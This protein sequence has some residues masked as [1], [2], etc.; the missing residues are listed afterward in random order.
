MRINSEQRWSV[1]KETVAG[2]QDKALELF[3]TKTVDARIELDLNRRSS[4]V[5]A[6]SPPPM[7]Q[8]EATQSPIAQEPPLEKEYDEHDD[9]DNGFEMNDN[10]VGD[11]DKYLT[12]E[13]MDHSIPYSRCYASDSDDD[14]PDE[15][16]DEDGL[17]AK[18]AERAEIFKKRIYNFDQEDGEK[19]P[20]AWARF[21]SL[22]RAQPDHDLEKHDLLDIFYSGL[23]IES[24]AYLDS[25]AGCVFRKRTPDDAEELL[26]KIGRN[27]DDWSTP[28][29]TPTPIVK[30][31]GMIKLNDEDMREAKKSLK[32][33]GIKPEDVKNLPPI[34]D[35]CETIPPSSMIEDPLYPEGHPKR[36]EQDSQLIKT[37]APSK[38]KKKKHKNVV[39]SSEP[40]N[41]PNSISISDAETESGNEHEEDND[42]NDTPDKEEIEKEPEKH[43][44]N[45]KYTKEDFITEKHGAVIDCNKGMV[46]FNVD[47]KEHTVYFPKRI[48]KDF[49]FHRSRTD[50]MV[51]YKI[52]NKTIDLPFSDF[53][54]AIRVPQWGSCEKI[55]GTPRELSNLYTRI[56]NGRSFSNDGGKI[57]S[58]QHPAIRYFAYF[59]TKGYLTKSYSRLCGAENT[60]EKRALRRAGIRRGN[61]LPEGEIDAIAIV[62]ELD[63]ISI[64]I[65]IIIIISTIYT[66]I[67]TAAP[68]HRCNNLGIAMNEVR[69]KLFT[70]SLSGKAAH[71]YKL[72]KNGDSID[73]EDI[74]PLFY[75]KF[76]PPSE[77]HKD[78]NRIYNFWP[79]DGESIAQAWGRLKSLM[80]KCPIH[81]LPGNV[82]ID[83]FYARLSFQDKTLLDTSCSG[84][85]TRNK[86]EFK[87]DLL[88]RIQE[89]TEGWENDKDR[90]SGIIYDYKC[91]E[92]F[93]DT[94][95]FRNM[96]AT[97]GLD[98]QVVA[99]LYKAF[100]SHYELPKKNFDKYHE[101]Y[102]DNVDS[103]V[104]K[105]VVIET[106]DNVIPEVYIE[107]T[108]FPAKM[109]EYSVISSAVN[110][111]EKKPKEPEEQ[112]KIE[113]AVA[114]VKDLVTENVEDGHIIFC[115]DASNIVSHPNKPKQVSVPMLS[116]RIGDHCYYGLCD[117]GA[118]VSAIPYELYTEIM[119]EIDSC[120]LEDIDV[121]IQLANRETISPIGIVRDVE[122]LCGKIKYPADFLV[123]GSAASDHCPIIFGRPFLNTCGAIIDCKKE[124]ILTKFA[125]EPY[126]F[127]F[128]K[129]TKTP[130]KADLPSNDFKMEQCASIVLVP[131][132][133]L[134][135]HLENSESEAFRKE[136][137]ELE[138]IFL[139]QPILKHDLPVEDL[140]TTPPPKEDP[141][142][143]L[144]PLPDN[145][146]YAHIDDKKIYPVIISS[147]LSEIE[148]ERLLEILKKHRGAIG[149]TLDDLKGISPSICQH[150]INM[151]DDAKP[152]VE[153]QRRLIP[154]MKEVVRN[155]VLKLL[156]A[157]IIYP[158]ADSRW[159]SPVHCVPKKGGM[160][161]VPNDND[162]LIPQRVV[163]GRMPF[164]LC[165]APATF[166]RCMSAIFHGFCESIVERCEE[167]NLVLN[168]EKCHFMVNEGIVLGHKI[169]ERGIEVDRAKVEAIEKM[170]YPRDVKGIRSVLGHAGFYRR[171]IKD[172]SKISKP[173]TN[174]LQKDVPFVFDD[175]C[176]EA[177]ET[178][179]KALTTAPVVEPPDWNLPFEIMC[180]ASDFA[181]GAVLGQRVDKKLN[182]IHYASKTLDAAQRNYATTEKELLAVVFACDKFRPYIV[183]SK[184]T[185]HTDHAA[186]R[187]LM[188]KKDAKPRLIRWVLLL[189]EF[190]LHIIDRKGADNPV[191]DNLSR[192]ENIAYDPVP[193]NDSFPNE[194][195]AVIKV[196][197]RESPCTMVS[198]NKDKGPLEE[199]IQDPELKEED[200]SEDE[201]EVEEAPRV[202]QRATI[203]SIG[204]ISNPSN[205]KRSARIATG[206]AVPRHYL[207]PRTSSPG[208]YSPFRNLIYD[209]QTERTPKVVLPSGWDIDRSNI[210]GEMKSE[211]E[212]WGNNSRSWDSPPDMIMSRVEHNSELIRNLTYEIED[213]KELVKKLVEKNPSPSPPK[214]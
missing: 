207:A 153:H 41:D 66:A 178:L 118:S 80:L 7:S 52:Y 205:T 16:L 214:E 166:Q 138:E 50:P 99:N 148:E 212:G 75:S 184:V 120:E 51:R 114:I 18:E 176:K 68:R 100:A 195:L 201:E 33:K 67:T 213:L 20:E 131:N 140:G 115:E 57:S 149:Y 55:R 130:Y 92:A 210:A 9:G 194:Q 70:I 169:S 158:I 145:L 39:E 63:I 95:K 186:I 132:N 98:S 144:K 192:L 58:I 180:D 197:S 94:D 193:V 171:F 209:R 22:I 117:I 188:T 1:Y 74:V 105:C 21:C 133:P 128:S 91:I 119:H 107:K 59:I 86:E 102:K 127:N 185:I 187:Y 14:G 89:N 164:G 112:I 203:A 40:V 101:P 2:S 122:V 196:S 54:T 71:W 168:W 27:H 29:P 134:Q 37:S 160:T 156:E 10:N 182:V 69:K 126:E 60:R 88:D 42:K 83:N 103:S 72:L 139:R 45:K 173:L 19:L 8:E 165:N 191:A 35:I 104:N 129:F 116:V 36:V 152:V 38:K 26:A 154:K 24:R 172:F 211:A 30:K 183:D 110:K 142:F 167:T 49:E 179:K 109:K 53:C 25:C 85:F 204:V 125:G 56:C 48:D 208:N 79:H 64:I 77:I 200:A 106:V 62:I 155:E 143:D 15:E 162:E 6:R 73:W 31:R 78:R 181:V 46:T 161:V 206:G 4:P 13:E 111:S 28:E 113:P 97:Y 32:E 3:A 82:I 11:L 151:E 170:P 84:S 177:F 5:Q 163:V 12:Q 17:T 141:V 174:L 199:D 47:D 76:Y 190:D 159:V 146:K 65:I 61:S 198:N 87:R 202:H 135:Q 175:D 123:L 121:V 108:P 34:E 44:K 189:Q 81:E 150:A 136:R 90:E 96:S 93:M 157:G 23:T 147:K 137:D 43:A 124:K